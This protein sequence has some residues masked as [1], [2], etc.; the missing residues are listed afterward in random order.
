M[1][2]TYDIE[3][4]NL[5]FLTG[6]GVASPFIT[7]KEEVP[8]KILDSCKVHEVPYIIIITNGRKRESSVKIFS[9]EGAQRFIKRDFDGDS[10]LLEQLHKKNPKIPDRESSEIGILQAIFSAIHEGR[11]NVNGGYEYIA[12]AY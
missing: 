12:E 4:G 11:L 10:E 5:V 1:S 8:Q 2:Y 7:D 3:E 9:K 6:G